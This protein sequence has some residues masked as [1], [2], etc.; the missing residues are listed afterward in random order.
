MR[1][2]VLTQFSAPQ[3]DTDFEKLQSLY[4]LKLNVHFSSDMASAWPI[5]HFR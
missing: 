5:G 3:M 1:Q 2:G 4:V